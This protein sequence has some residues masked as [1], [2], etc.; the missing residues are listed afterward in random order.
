M[1]SAFGYP[2][3]QL[4]RWKLASLTPGYHVAPLRGVVTHAGLSL[5]H[6]CP[7]PRHF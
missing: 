3:L 2:G 7:S 5:N 1:M 4:T 6:E